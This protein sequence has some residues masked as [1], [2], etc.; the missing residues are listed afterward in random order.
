MIA[1]GQDATNI[2]LGDTLAEDLFA[3]TTFD[4]C[5]SNPPYGVDW[6]ASEDAVKAERHA[7]ATRPASPAGLP[8]ISDGQMLFLQH[9][10]SKMRPVKDGGGRAGIVLNGSPLFNGGAESGPSEIRRW[11]LE[12]DLVDA[13]VALPTNMFYNTGIATYVWILDNAKPAERIGKVQ[14][15]DGS[16][17][18]TK[19]RK[20]LGDK[21]VRSTDADREQILKLYEAFDETASTRRSS[22]PTPSATGPSPSSDRWS[23]RTGAPSWTA[24]ATRSRTRKC[25]APRTSRSPAAETR[26]ATR[27]ASRRSR[28]TSTPKFCRIC[29]MPGSTTRRPRSGLRSR[30]HGTSTSTPATIPCRDRHRPKGAGCRRSSSSFGRWKGEQPGALPGVPASKPALASRGPYWVDND[31]YCATSADLRPAPGTPSTPNRTANTRSS[32]VPLSP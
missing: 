14:L 17:F 5:L 9:L 3:G 23:T 30:S 2:R 28:R 21:V 31:K 20:N 15:I 27:A 7:T 29:R 26:R 8:P 4:Y 22:R 32:S 10:A 25:A 11:L 12:Y 16:G 6:K 1:K 24:R 19:M 18:Y 13:I